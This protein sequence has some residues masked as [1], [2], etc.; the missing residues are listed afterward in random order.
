LLNSAMINAAQS[1]NVVVGLLHERLITAHR[2][3]SD[4]V[5]AVQD[6]GTLH[7]VDNEELLDEIRNELT[8]GKD[9]LK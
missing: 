2:L 9:I 6:Q 1:L 7:P 5:E 8:N 4:V 3:L